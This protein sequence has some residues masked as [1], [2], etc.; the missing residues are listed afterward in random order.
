MQLTSKKYFLI[1]CGM[2][3]FSVLIIGLL[4]MY[5]SD[6]NQ[7]L[8]VLDQIN[9]FEL[10]EVLTETSYQ[11]DNDKIKLIAFIFIHCPDGVCPMTLQDFSQ[12]QDQLK[13][14]NKFGQEVE[15]LA[16]TFDPLRDTPEALQE[17]AQHF[18]VDSKGWRFLRGSEEVTEQI[19]SDLKFF[20]AFE[21]TGEG[22]HS[23]TM[24]LVDQNHQVRS[25]YSMSSASE[26]MN[27]EKILRDIDT[28][29]KEKSE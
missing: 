11:S 26:S 6:A 25:Y 23:T 3:I 20:Y 24:F 8:D 2:M 16:I 21:D 5:V 9:S 27:Q 17:Y 13:E 28:L 14:Q 7:K 18:N 10:D 29:I 4:W 12:L 15:L 22:M 19:A 1:L